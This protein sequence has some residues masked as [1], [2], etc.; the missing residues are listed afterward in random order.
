[1]KKQNRNY[2]EEINQALLSYENYKPWHDKSMD[3]ICGRID[4]CWKFRHIT[5]EQMSELCDRC[6]TIFQNL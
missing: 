4:W 3:W 6:C 2:Y 5:R 1:M